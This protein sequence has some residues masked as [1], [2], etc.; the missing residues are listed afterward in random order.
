MNIALS[1]AARH[2]WR[3]VVDD[4]VDGGALGPDRSGGRASI[5]EDVFVVVIVLVYFLVDYR[6]FR[7]RLIKFSE[8]WE[9][10]F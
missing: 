10:N 8:S 4:I 7:Q 1:V 9:F 5:E 3:S 2:Y 6:R